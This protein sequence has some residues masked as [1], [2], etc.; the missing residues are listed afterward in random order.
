MATTPLPSRPR[1]IGPRNTFAIVASQYHASYVQSMVEHAR[2]ELE[3]IAEGT[4][5]EVIE[6]PGAFEIPVAVQEVAHR[7]G[8]NGIIALGLI[9]R[10]ETAHADLIAGTLTNSLQKISLEHRVPVIHEV[11]LVQNDE[12]ARKRC[13]EEE[14][15]RGTE[16]ARVAVRMANVMEEF[17]RR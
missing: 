9:I 11:L 13:L 2:Q 17:A 1:Q 10:G 16:A 3:A 14:F 4:T 7:G 6:V 12:Q 5:V 15:N 8:V